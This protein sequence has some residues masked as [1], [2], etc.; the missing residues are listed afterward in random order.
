MQRVMVGLVFLAAL[1]VLVAGGKLIE[2][3]DS[4]RIAI[5]QGVYG[6]LTFATTPGPWGQW[7]GT[8]ETFKRREQLWFKDKD[9]FRIRF[10]DNGHGTISGSLAWEMPVDQKC[11]TKIFQQ[12]RTQQAVEEQLVKPVTEKAVY[13]SGPLMS[14]TESAAERRNELLQLIE[15]QIENGAY[16]TQVVKVE[17]EDPITKEKRVRAV[18]QAVR[19]KNGNVIRVTDSP[20]KEFCI[21]TFNL[22]INEVRYDQEVEAQIQQQQQAIMA[23]RIA[24]ANAQK[25]AQ[26]A[27]T[28][29]EQGKA[30][31]AKAKWEQEKVNATVVAEAEGKKKAE[32]QN[33]LAMQFYKQ[34]QTAKGEAEYAYRSKLMQADNALE[35]R[36]D[37]Y[38]RVQELW[39]KAFAQY[40]GS[41]VPSV[42]MGGQGEGK[43]ATAIETVMST[44]AAKAARDLA[45]EMRATSAPTGK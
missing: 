4:D 7:F 1:V 12:Y 9:A 33:A 3:V 25:A 11:L 8:V 6:N 10:N 38:I 35:K 28:V 44:L 22:T 20:L 31:A 36:L 41:M 37:A 19:D 26:D 43:G 16:M 39:A 14:S 30:D 5:I 32:E 13:T 27:L 23:V 40:Q 24:M 15:D 29:A 18:S 42:V 45:V 17:E 2:F 34:A 21:K